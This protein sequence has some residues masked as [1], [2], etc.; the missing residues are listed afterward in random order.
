MTQKYL[1]NKR[2]ISGRA[3]ARI[4]AEHKKVFIRFLEAREKK[5]A[6]WNIKENIVEQF[7]DETKKDI[8]E[9]LSATIPAVMVQGAKEN[10]EKWK[11]LLPSG[12][13]LAFDLPTSPASNYVR[14]LIDL[15][16]SDYQGS[17]LKTT[18]DELR[19]IIANGLDDKL[20]YG[21]IAKRISE[22]DPFVFSKSRGK[23]IAVNEI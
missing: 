18:R 13:S 2:I 16:L 9:Y 15:H 6:F 22:T 20:S 19:T 7:I 17:I 4:L 21:D 23:L 3:I 1:K 5:G 14:A 12:Y 10:I 8:P 11:T